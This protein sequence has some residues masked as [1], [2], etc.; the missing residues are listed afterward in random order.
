ML[1][2]CIPLPTCIW[3][4]TLSLDILY[5]RSCP[6]YTLRLSTIPCIRRVDQPIPSCIPSPI[7]SHSL[8]YSLSPVSLRL[9][10]IPYIP[11]TG[12]T[13]PSLYTLSL[14]TERGS[15]PS[16]LL[17]STLDTL[18]QPIYDLYPVPLRALSLS[19][20]TAHSLFPHSLFPHSLFPYPEDRL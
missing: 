20:Y 1:S 10:T 8:L 2:L 7:Y 6:G 3:I 14:Y 5:L 16:L 11:Y 17:I 4:S 15:A 12:R 18:F 19:R 9:S 13:I